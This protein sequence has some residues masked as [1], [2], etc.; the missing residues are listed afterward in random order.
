MTKI[1]DTT[2]L[3][4]HHNAKGGHGLQG[5]R[6]SGDFTA[7]A[8]NVFE[9]KRIGKG[10]ERHS[11]KIKQLKSRGYGWIKPICYKITGKEDEM[12]G[13]E[14]FVEN[15]P[16]KEESDSTDKVLVKKIIF[17]NIQIIQPWVNY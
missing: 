10:T 1:F 5:V 2:W 16:Q 13:F 12:L 11:F 17:T 4:L 3:M 6:G 15:I 7:M 14:Q 8:N 9:I